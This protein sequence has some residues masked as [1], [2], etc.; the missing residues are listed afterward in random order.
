[1]TKHSIIISM[2]RGGR[3]FILNNEYD[4]TSTAF[5]PNMRCS[6]CCKDPALKLVL[7]HD[8]DTVHSVGVADCNAPSSQYK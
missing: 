5:L 6:G 1:M 4:I 8:K 3:Y 7:V 2:G